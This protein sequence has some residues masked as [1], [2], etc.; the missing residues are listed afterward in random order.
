MQLKLSRSQREVGALS[1]RVIFCLDARVQ[2]GAREAAEVIRYKLGSQVIYNSEASKRQLAKG[3]ATN[4]G[5]F[6]GSLKQIGYV[7][8]AL[9][10]LN[11]TIDSLQRGQ[12]IECKDLNELL[13][14]EEAIMSACERLKGLLETAATFDGR[15]VVI[16]FI[17][18]TPRVSSTPAAPMPKLELPS[19]AAGADRSVPT[20]AATASA[21]A[22]TEPSFLGYDSAADQQS[23]FD[24]FMARTLGEKLML[25]ALGAVV[26]IY[27]ISHL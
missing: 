14:A 18:E 16:D 4:D 19:A 25:L 15:E 1:R 23:P 7:G 13:G 27:F 8:L 21:A 5:S 3:E 12:H 9:L 22:I 20:V 6:T 26:L 17:T 11:I 2:L 10:N 24:W